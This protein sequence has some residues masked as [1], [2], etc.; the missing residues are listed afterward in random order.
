MISYIDN[1]FVIEM[2][3][4]SYV[5]TGGDV[6]TALYWGEKLHG[7]E[8]GYLSKKRGHSSFDPDLD[9]NREEYGFWDSY[10]VLESCL[11]IN[12][13]KNRQLDMRFEDYF[14]RTEGGKESLILHF[15]NQYSSL[16]AEIVYEVYPEF[17][18]IGRS[19]RLINDG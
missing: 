17:D 15:Q 1:L 4:S 19:M 10:S 12:Y 8:L 13:E 3:S 5:F 7:E 9:R 14:I 16:K 11:K 2:K 6:P 18:I